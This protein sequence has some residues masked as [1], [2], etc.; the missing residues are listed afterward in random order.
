MDFANNTKL[1]L[2]KYKSAL[3]KKIGLGKNASLFVH[4]INEFHKHT[5]SLVEIRLRSG[6]VSFDCKKGCV[7]C[8]N[9]RVEAL[10]PEIFAISHYLKSKPEEEL[11]AY[12]DK[13]RNHVLVTKGKKFKEYNHPCPFLASSGACDVYKV[14]PHKCRAYLSVDVASCES[15]NVAQED[16]HIN[17][18]EKVLSN[19][20]IAV[21][22]SKSCVMHP[23]ELGQSVLA[24]LEDDNLQNRWA[25]GEQVFEL[26]PEGIMLSTRW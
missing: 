23:A 22:K 8:C 1:I 13:L 25:A 18:A 2:K 3:K 10:P 5:D 26:L 17:M 7:A 14:R 16:V 11:A 24:A 15:N 4:A 21:Y 6:A 9:L 12:K 20:C 19:D